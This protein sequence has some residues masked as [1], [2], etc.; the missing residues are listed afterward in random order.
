[1]AGCDTVRYLAYQD[2]EPVGRVM[3]IIHHPHNRSSGANAARFFAFECI[4]NLEVAHALIHEVEQWARSFGISRMIGPFGFSDKDPQGALIMGF[5]HNAV[6]TTP[7][8]FPYYARHLEAE[9]YAKE[10]DLVEY[11]IPVTPEIPEFYIRIADRILR[12]PSI[13][14]LEFRTKRELKPFIQPVLGLMNETFRDIYGFNHLSPADI[15]SLA[16]QYLPVLDPE[17]IKVVTANGDPVAFII[18]MP[19]V[20]PGLRKAHGRLFPFG[21]FHVLQDLKHSDYLVL[22]AG[23]I[24]KDFQGIG[25]DALMGK[26]MLETAHRRGIRLI[27]SHLELETNLKVRAEMERAGGKVSKMYRIFGKDLS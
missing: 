21:I 12:N 19:D 5:Q 25:L 22:L 8:N 3:G 4:D 14:C 15:K 20:G 9:G 18:G 24:R 13:G 23:A 1:M 11:H 26:K 27:N 6:I 16:D 17:F 7:Y 2:G 10:L